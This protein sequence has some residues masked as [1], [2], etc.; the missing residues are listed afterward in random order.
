[1]DHNDDLVIF[2]C[3]SNPDIRKIPTKNYNSVHLV[4]DGLDCILIRW[5][6]YGFHLFGLIFSV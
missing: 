3:Y 6:K 5:K 1:M 4:L 2:L